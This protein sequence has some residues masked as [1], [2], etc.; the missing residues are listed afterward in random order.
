MHKPDLPARINPWN[1]CRHPACPWY[2]PTC[3]RGP[4]ELGAECHQCRMLLGRVLNSGR[5]NSDRL[6]SGRLCQGHKHWDMQWTWLVRDTKQWNMKYSWHDLTGIQTLKHEIQLTWLVRDTNIATCNELHM[7]CQKKNGLH[8]SLLFTGKIVNFMLFFFSNNKCVW[9]TTRR[10]PLKCFKSLTFF[11][12]K[13]FYK[14][15]REEIF[16][17]LETFDNN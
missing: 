13:I 5:L 7:T 16:R 11:G 3:W 17:I 1:D 8:F 14:V 2:W 15:K 10:T 4:P 6:N 9:S 12:S